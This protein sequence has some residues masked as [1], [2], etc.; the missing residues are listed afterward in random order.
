MAARLQAAHRVI[1]AGGPK[2]GSLIRDH[3][4]TNASTF[5]PHLQSAASGGRRGLD[6]AAGGG[7][8]T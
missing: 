6:R 3:G 8:R 2:M 5:Y 1:E 7:S 4:F